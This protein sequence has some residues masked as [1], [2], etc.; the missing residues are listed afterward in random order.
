M[1]WHFQL[2]GPA[3]GPYNMALDESLMRRA[4][5]T[6]EAVFRVYGWSSPTLSLGR[7]QRA[8]G[9]YDESAA[10]A[11]GIGFVRRPTGGRALLHDHEVT[12][13]ATMP[14]ADPDGAR[15][16]YDFINEV[17]LGAL[18]RLGVDAERA[19]TT[20]AI[21][22]G[23][24]PCFDVPAEREIVVGAQK[25]VGSA[26]W[27]RDGALLQHGSILIRDDQAVI[28]R[29]TRA[30]LGAPPAAASLLD[31]LGR[32]PSLDELSVMLRESLETSIGSRASLLAEDPDLE[33]DLTQLRAL[34]ADTSWTWRR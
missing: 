34:Y 10:G 2:S 12:Y 30:A 23:L 25:L 24:R 32:E 3:D 11:L 14:V 4:A 21:P 8:H 16:A 7:N 19:R 27:R 29:I 1:R 20:S 15:A 28:A 17:L 9:C 31:A 18:K 22:P 13:S 5:R 33:R 6:G 26:Q